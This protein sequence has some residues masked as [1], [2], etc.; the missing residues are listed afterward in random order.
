MK[1]IGIDFTEEK[2]RKQFYSDDTDPRV[3]MR[4]LELGIFAHS[5]GKVLIVTGIIR[6]KEKNIE[7]YGR[8]EPSGHRERPARAIDF[9]VDEPDADF[10]AGL[11]NYH[12]MYMDQGAYYTLMNHDV[13][14]GL[15]WHLQVPHN[16]RIN[17]KLYV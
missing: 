14:T 12:V 5:R 3:R 1:S 11:K 17:V 6:S 13:G 16:P 9:R 15:H 2:W 10:S 7:T 8:D 4:F